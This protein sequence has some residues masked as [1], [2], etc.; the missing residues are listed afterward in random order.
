M[1]QRQTYANVK[2]KEPIIIL[3]VGYVQSV[4]TQQQK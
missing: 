1:L 4:R 3:P 2:Y